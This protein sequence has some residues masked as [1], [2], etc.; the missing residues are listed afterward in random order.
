M[1]PCVFTLWCRVRYMLEPLAMRLAVSREPE[2]EV[3]PFMAVNPCGCGVQAVSFCYWTI[4][5]AGLS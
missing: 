5:P 1:K 3:V 4:R 2:L